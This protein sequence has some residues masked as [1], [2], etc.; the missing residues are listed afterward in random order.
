MLAVESDLKRADL[1]YAID[2]STRI[3]F[4]HVDDKQSTALPTAKTA[5]ASSTSS[6]AT[7]STTSMNFSR[8][9]DDRVPFVGLDAVH[10]SLVELF[11]MRLRHS[12]A[13]SALGVDAPRAI[14]LHGK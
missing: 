7:T 3:E 12:A 6:T 9:I 1:V 4:V 2:H 11:A 8:D 10:A 5:T 13:L 14:L